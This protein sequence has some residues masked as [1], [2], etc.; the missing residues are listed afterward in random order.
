METS[1]IVLLDGWKLFF[2]ENELPKE[3]NSYIGDRVIFEFKIILHDQLGLRY[4]IVYHD[5]T[6]LLII[7]FT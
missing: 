6:L 3:N 4:Y 5:L 1:G 2:C 7:D